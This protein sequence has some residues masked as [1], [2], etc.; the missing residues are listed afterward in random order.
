MD[1]ADPVLVQ[2]LDTYLVSADVVGAET[3]HAEVVQE[4]VLLE[5]FNI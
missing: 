3:L 5:V 1:H 2:V 4:T